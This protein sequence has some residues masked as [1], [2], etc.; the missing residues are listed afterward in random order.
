MFAGFISCRE[1]WLDANVYFQLLSFCREVSSPLAPLSS[2]YPS[3][4]V[5]RPGL[6][7]DP[8]SCQE[9]SVEMTEKWKLKTKK[10][11]NQV[12]CVPEGATLNSTDWTFGKQSTE[13]SDKNWA[14]APVLFLSTNKKGPN[15]PYG[16]DLYPF[17]GNQA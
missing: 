13:L 8:Q 5:F 10:L 12:N 1:I 11:Q 17:Q 14:Q 6:A 3:N 16:F 15:F 4:P 9:F 2:C 7:G